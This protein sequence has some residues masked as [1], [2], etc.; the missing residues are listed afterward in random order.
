MD[1]T[2]I[3][4]DGFPLAITLIGILALELFAMGIPIANLLIITGSVRVLQAFF[5]LYMISH[6]A[7]KV[8][9]PGLNR[10]TWI[11]GIA[12][13]LGWSAVFGLFALSAG[14]LMFVAGIN[15]F[16]MITIR[17]PADNVQLVLFFLV[18]GCIGPFAEELFFR[19][20]VYGFLRKYGIF[21]AIT[22]STVLFVLAHSVGGIALTHLIGGLVFAAAYEH[23]K[24]ILVPITI[25]VM[26]NLALFSTGIF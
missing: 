26:G 20:V 5:I 16:D 19:G 18:A 3:R 25:H 10:S 4:Y 17:L 15:P 14:A 13:G 1:T 2:T 9:I 11:K 8:H 7:G 24:N 22:G 12:R 23:E 6:F 21:A